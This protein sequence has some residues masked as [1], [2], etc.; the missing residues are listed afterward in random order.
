M[1]IVAL[2]LVHPKFKHEKK[3]KTIVKYEEPTREEPKQEKPKPPKKKSV[4][5][6][7]KYSPDEFKGYLEKKHEIV[8]KPKLKIPEMDPTISFPEFMER[9]NRVPKHMEKASTLDDLSPEMKVLML[10]G[11]FDKKYFD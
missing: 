9:R 10:S 5:E 3:E 2:F 4:F 7:V 8:S 11:V 1:P 6:E